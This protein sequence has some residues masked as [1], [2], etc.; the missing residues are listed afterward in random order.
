MGSHFKDEYYYCHADMS[1]QM[2]GIRSVYRI[3]DPMSLTSSSLFRPQEFSSEHQ[4]DSKQSCHCLPILTLKNIDI[5]RA[6]IIKY[7]IS[8]QLDTVT[9]S[10]SIEDAKYLPETF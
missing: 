2:S 3:R 10:D 1:R 8:K 9:T 7:L 6:D 5:V 4:E